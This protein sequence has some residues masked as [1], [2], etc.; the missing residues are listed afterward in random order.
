MSTFEPSAH[1]RSTSGTF[2][3]SARS[4]PDIELAPAPQ[5]DPDGWVVRGDRRPSV[6][7]TALLLADPTAATTGELTAALAGFDAMRAVTWG[8]ELV[9]DVYFEY[10][11]RPVADGTH[12]AF[13]RKPV[14]HAEHG[15]W[16]PVGAVPRGA[17]AEFCS[18]SPDDDC[19][20]GSCSYCWGRPQPQ[21]LDWAAGLGYGDAVDA[22]REAGPSFI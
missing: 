8:A 19:L 18:G 22:F 13:R 2:T 1:P 11:L 6:H 5:V 4:E 3:I 10:A 17:R 16:E 20:A 7:V 12:G 14:G 9:H 21:D 15:E